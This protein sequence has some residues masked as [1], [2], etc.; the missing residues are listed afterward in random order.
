MFPY[1]RTT[2]FAR[3]SLGRVIIDPTDGWPERNEELVGKGTT[4][5]IDVLGLGFTVAWKGLTLLANA[6]YRGGHLVY[7]D[8]GEDMTFTGSGAITTIYGRETFIWPNSSYLDP[9][10]GK[11]LPNNNI[12]VGAYQAMYQGFGDQGFTRGL[13]GIGE[14]YATSAAFWKI[15]EI[16][17]SYDIPASVIGGV[18]FIRGISVSAFAR[19]PFMW[20]PSDNIYTDPEF[21]NTNGNATGINTSIN[22]PPTRQF[23]GVIRVVF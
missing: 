21:S 4:L 16:S 15:R 1:L 6:E 10:S 7:H 8:L 17:L 12:A 20:L 11:Y 3:D 13:A 14:T 2:A 19:N 18:K 9:A 22:T 23:G 5:P